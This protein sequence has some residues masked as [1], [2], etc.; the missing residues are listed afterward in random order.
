MKKERENIMKP[1][2]EMYKSS[3]PLM[4]MYKDIKGR[5]EQKVNNFPCM[6][7]F[8]NSQF[9]EGM[10]KLGV[11]SED[12]LIS[13]GGGGY[14]AKSN[15]ADFVNLINHLSDELME[16]MLS[17]KDFAKVVFYYELMNHEAFY[18]YDD[19]TYELVEMCGFT[20][21][22]YDN[23]EML[24]NAYSEAFKDYWHDMCEYES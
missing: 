1:T 9:E 21:E 19:M 13:I 2:K 6:W 17:N 18:A 14:I 20:K 7:A 4:Q 8:S 23:N 10:R 22:E 5:Q 15:K 11:A 16:T 12:E 24:K 3:S